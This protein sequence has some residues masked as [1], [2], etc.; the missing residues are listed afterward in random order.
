MKK[1][2]IGEVI[3][4]EYENGK[5]KKSILEDYMLVKGVWAL[6]G[7]NRETSEN[8]CLQVGKSKNVGNELLYDIACLHFLEARMDGSIKYINHFEEYCDFNYESNQVQEYLYPHIASQ[9]HSFKFV[10]IHDASDMEI[11]RNYAKENSA[12]YWRNGSPYGVKKT[13][14][15]TSKRM[16]VIGDMFPD[17]GEI[18][19][20]EDLIKNI[21]D[22]LGYCSKQAKRLI[23][24]CV[25]AGF[26]IPMDDKLYTR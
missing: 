22:N 20:E 15:L 3:Y 11:E 5:I 21:K 1:G 17:G 18:Y 6:Y 7:I 23:N 10:Y 24:D 2:K 13:L 25:N 16:Q 8:R 12:K 9:W 19:S 26:L 4:E 14:N